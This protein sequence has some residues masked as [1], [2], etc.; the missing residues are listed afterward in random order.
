MA[1]ARR[2]A[3]TLRREARALLG[4]LALERAELSVLLTDDAAMRELNLAYRGKDSPTDV[5]SFAQF[6]GLTADA[7]PLLPLG[8]IVISFDTASR[9]AEVLG[10]A[11]HARLRTLLIHGLLHILGYDHERS[12]TEARRMFARERELAARLDG[13]AAMVAAR[14]PQRRVVPPAHAAVGSAPTHPGGRRG[15]VARKRATRP[16]PAV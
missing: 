7:D 2:C 14:A 11:T 4:L 15:R 8:D 6:D 1:R 5:L 9:Q 10:V 3:P 16:R 13:S 12:P